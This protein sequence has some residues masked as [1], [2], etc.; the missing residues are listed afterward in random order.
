MVSIFFF[1]KSASACA[2]ICGVMAIRLGIGIRFRVRV[3]VRI[4]VGTTQS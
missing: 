4:S 2:L 1:G 3:S